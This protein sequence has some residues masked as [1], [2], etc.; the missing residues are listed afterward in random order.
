MR[1]S[2]A[3]IGGFRCICSF[4]EP[5]EFVKAKV[6]P[7]VMT[8][9]VVPSGVIKTLLPRSKCVLV[10]RSHSGNISTFQS[11]TGSQ[12]NLSR[13]NTPRSKDTIPDN[14]FRKKPQRVPMFPSYH[15]E[16]TE[17]K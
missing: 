15:N 11:F 7:I 2:D 12:N 4:F 6:A 9:A 1:A 16:N 3:I 13:A 17:N 10:K 5:R 14:S 8:M